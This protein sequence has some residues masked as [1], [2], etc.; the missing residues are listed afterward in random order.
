MFY[1]Q[2]DFDISVFTFIE[3]MKTATTIIYM[4]S[5]DREHGRLDR[6]HGRLDHFPLI[7]ES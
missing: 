6:E 3:N 1:N 4:L 7:V 2:I 5:V